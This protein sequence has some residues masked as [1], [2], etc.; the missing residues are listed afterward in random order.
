MNSIG[1]QIV[2]QK[3]SR[4][5]KGFSSAHRDQFTYLPHLNM[6]H[7]DTTVALELGYRVNYGLEEQRLFASLTTRQNHSICNRWLV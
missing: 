4:L 6:F 2:G 3:S 1:I 7:F 5:G